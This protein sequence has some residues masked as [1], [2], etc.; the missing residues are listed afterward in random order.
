ML[1]RLFASRRPSPDA[2]MRRLL[3]FKHQIVHG[4]TTPPQAILSTWKA[5]WAKDEWDRFQ[6]DMQ[7]RSAEMQRAVRQAGLWEF[8]TDDER[9]FIA[10]P[11]LE[12]TEQQKV[13]ASWLMEGAVCLL[14]ALG[15]V[16]SIPPYDAQA[17]VE[18]LRSVPA[19]PVDALAKPTTLRAKADLEAARACAELW[20]WRSRTRQLQEQGGYE[21]RLPAGMTFERIIAVA[22]ES[23]AANADIPGVVGDDFPAFGR[24]Y[25]EATAAEYATLTSIGM[26][27][28]RAFNWLCGLAPRNRWDDT[29]T[30]T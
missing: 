7:A 10:S 20:H 17:D 5:S 23:A 14:W 25:R 29:P 26:E 22:A 27:R 15:Y 19:E 2:V 28:H 3:I 11:L 21:S 9:I 16:Q 6:S 24:S 4:L 1:E 12:V 13:N 8:M 18:L 30:D